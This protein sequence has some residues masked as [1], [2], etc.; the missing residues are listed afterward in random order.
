MYRV[1]GKE[2][3][4]LRIGNDS[5]VLLEGLEVSQMSI[6]KNIRGSTLLAK[7]N[8]HEYG[9]MPQLPRNR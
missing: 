5:V 8:L 7:T 3:E 4:T 6:G 2:K 1:Q 9:E